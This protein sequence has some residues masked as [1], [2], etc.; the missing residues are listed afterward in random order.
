MDHEWD[1]FDP[2]L[3]IVCSIY[4]YIYIYIHSCVRNIHKTYAF[5]VLFVKF[6]NICSMKVHN[7]PLNLLK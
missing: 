1:G 5:D 6:L 4:Y 3:I 2:L 7:M